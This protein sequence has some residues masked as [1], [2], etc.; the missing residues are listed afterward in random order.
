LGTGRSACATFISGAGIETAIGCR[1][2]RATAITDHLTNGG[3]IEVE[4]RLQTITAD[5]WI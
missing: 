3:R 4:Q 1:A 2:F 5:T